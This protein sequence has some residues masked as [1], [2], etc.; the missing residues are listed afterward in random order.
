MSTTRPSTTDRLT[1]RDFIAKWGPGG[2]AYTLNERAGAQPHFIDL[3]RVLAVAE[4]GDAENYCFERGV[5]KTGGTGLRKNGFADVWLRGRFAW[6]YKSPG[7]SLR[8][9]LDQLMRYALPLENPP[10][11]IVSDRLRIEV[12]THFT[13]TPS[14]CHLFALE[15]LSKHDTQQRLRAIW[16]SPDAFK[17]RKTN[18]DITEEAALTFAG[19]AKR[20]RA[21][22]VPA[23]QVSHFL[24]QC[25][26]CFFSEDVGLL[27]EKLFE[28]LVGVNVVPDRMRVQL[29]ALFSTMRDGG[30]FGAEDIPWF[31]GGL[32]KAV[33]V[34]ALTV[35]DVNALK[36]ASALNWSAIDPSIFGTLFER[37]LDP[38]VRSQLGANYTDPA[39]IQRIIDPVVKRPMLAEW[40]GVRATI[41]ALMEDRDRLRAEAERI[42]STTPELKRKYARLRTSANAAERA[43]EDAFGKFLERLRLFRV[44]DPAC[45]SGNFL[46]LAL[47]CLKDIEHQANI[48]AEQLGLER[49]QD[50]TGPHNVL[51]IELNEFAAE[52]ARI[53]VWIGE[54][55]WR[56]QKGYGFK[57]NPVLEPLDHIECRDAVMNADGT[58]A[59]WPRA[60]VVTGNP[61]FVGDKKMRGELGGEYTER[62]RAVYAGRVP[63][64]ADLVCYWFEKARALI[65]AGSLE[66]AGLVSTNS[67]RG[68]A[69]AIVRCSTGSRRRHASLR[70][71]A[72]SPG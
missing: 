5:I 53:T 4:P 30:L 60:D 72:M 45:G 23:E 24:T 34:P 16:E 49:K 58:A 21:A 64:G 13:G 20:M 55:Q 26:F 71:G 57:L 61:P 15:D 28:R 62:L 18:R 17:P 14:E 36:A 65:E 44:L 59:E 48:E 25:V 50:V 1:A 37:G 38:S 10:L 47:K 66:R 22:G 68:G 11:L 9:A 32:F 27:P 8:T 52:L 33:S 69:G 41:Q 19:T 54:L 51:G 46:Y 63:G 2:P 29:E 67:I 39:T 31:N 3:C 42:P 43:A 12:H 56:I 40:A 6:E 7:G 35:D 70:P